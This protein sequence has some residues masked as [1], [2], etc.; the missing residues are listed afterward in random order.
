MKELQVNVAIIGA[1]TA[2]LGAYRGA[3]KYTDNLVLIEGGPYGTTC[4]RVGCM[5]SKLLIASAEAATAVREASALGVHADNVSIDATQVMDRVKSE[6]D[7]FVGF[8]VDAVEGIPAQERVRGYARFLDDHTLAVD[9]HTIISAESVVIA[10]GSTPVVPPS[11]QGLDDRVIVNDDV[12]AWDTLPGSVAVFGPGVIGLEL[13]QA[14][15][16][17]GVEVYVFGR[18]GNVGPLSDPEL[19][20]YSTRTFAEEF[21]LNPN[22]QVTKVPAVHEG[23]EVTFTCLDGGVRTKRFDY[24]LSATGRREPRRFCYRNSVV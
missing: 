10:T 13:G 3:K 9:E 19:V 15:H 6:R 11:L 5:P 22:A 17:L 2:G 4:A 12:F 1:G 14:L 20:S 7:R 8:V 18:S 23:V 21:Y 16:R 24:V